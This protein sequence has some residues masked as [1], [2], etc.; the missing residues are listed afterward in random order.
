MSYKKKYLKYKHKYLYLKEIEG[1]MDSPNLR[2][3]R[4][5]QKRNEKISQTQLIRSSDLSQKD[6]RQKVDTRQVNPIQP[7][8]P[9]QKDPSQKDSR[10]KVDTRQVNP[11]QPVNA[12][13]KVNPR[14]VNP[15]QKVDTRQVNPST[16]TE[17][18]L[19]IINDIIKTIIEN[20][21]KGDKVI[22]KKN[23]GSME[24]M[25]NQC[26][27]IS[28][29]QYLKSK[30][31]T[32]TLRELRTN[33]GLDSSTE[34]TMF[35][36]DN[37][38]YIH[39]VEEICIR[40]NLLIIVIPVDHDGKSI[41]KSSLFRIFGSRN[42]N[43]PNILFIAN[44]GQ[45]HFELATDIQPSSKTKTSKTRTTYKLP[46]SITLPTSI[47]L[48]TTSEQSIS[49]PE[50]TSFDPNLKIRGTSVKFSELTR[51]QQDTFNQHNKFLQEQHQLKDQEKQLNEQL[52]ELYKEQYEI[53]NSNK[54][55]KEK[56]R[57]LNELD[58]KIKILVGYIINIERLI[59]INTDQILTL[60]SVINEMEMEI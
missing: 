14:Q 24:R 57:Q 26:F 44:Y 13:Q 58:D 23:T 36:T 17:N 9:S 60:E 50:T 59:L 21:N 39:A 5:D 42:K 12:R 47:S 22:T 52:S 3:L 1:G 11:I 29:H 10:Q 38:K 49:S 53:Q 15:R 8:N 48:T 54:N 18:Y 51:D 37:E 32:L 41:V 27:W 56:S 43:N 40:Y 46:T 2:E 20:I 16:D 28:I 6:P 19:V 55:K 33:A 7:I 25:T 34:Y 31:I 30:G 4:R 45:T 35:D